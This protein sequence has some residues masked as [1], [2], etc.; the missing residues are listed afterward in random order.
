MWK[1]LPIH[2]I[3][4]FLCR[5][6][7]DVPS[8][9]GSSGIWRPSVTKPSSSLSSSSSPSS[10]SATASILSKESKR[11]VIIKQPKATGRRKTL[12]HIMFVAKSIEQNLVGLKKNRLFLVTESGISVFICT[13]SDRR[14]WY[15]C[16]SL[17]VLMTETT[18]SKKFSYFTKTLN[19]QATSWNKID[20]LKYF[21]FKRQNIFLKNM[22]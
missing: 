18:I 1:R 6:G 10:V 13:S 16:N 5:I 4:D 17:C 12:P 2:Y 20:E 22:K 15:F 14:N 21:F 3:T 19:N 11:R 9:C 8:V 7:E